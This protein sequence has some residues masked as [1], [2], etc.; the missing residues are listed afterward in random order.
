MHMVFEHASVT[1]PIV[2]FTY[3]ECVEKNWI[4]NKSIII[5]LTHVHWGEILWWS[6]IKRSYFWYA[7]WDT[8][9]NEYWNVNERLIIIHRRALIVVN[10]QLMG[11]RFYE[12][13]FRMQSTNSDVQYRIV[14]APNKKNAIS[15]V[16]R[17][18]A[19]AR[20]QQQMNCPI[21]R[22]TQ[23]GSIL[24]S[25]LYWRQSYSW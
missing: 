14:D 3:I 18:I 12:T 7:Q 24:F 10:G 11:N 16:G 20:Q 4:V 13:F 2:M 6:I 22:S 5:K 17:C 19:T 1:E 23:L 21:N 25:G 9:C 8:G 15:S